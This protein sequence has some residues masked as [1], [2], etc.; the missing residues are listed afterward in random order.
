MPDGLKPFYDSLLGSKK[1][2]EEHLG[3]F[4]HFNTFLADSANA[5]KFYDGVIGDGLL[6]AEDLGTWEHFNRFVQKKIGVS[7][8][9]IPGNGKPGTGYQTEQMLA[10]L[11]EQERGMRSEIEDVSKFMGRGD[12]VSMKPVAP[13]PVQADFWGRPGQVTEVPETKPYYPGEQYTPEEAAQKGHDLSISLDA[14][15]NAQALVKEIEGVQSAHQL[16]GSNVFKQAWEGFANSGLAK[17]FWT[18]GLSEIDRSFDMLSIANKMRDG[19]EVTEEEEMLIGVYGMYQD[20]LQKNDASTAYMVG[21]GVKEMIPYMVSFAATGGVGTAARGGVQALLKTSSVGLKKMLKKRAYQE[22]TKEVGKRTLAYGVGAAAQTPLMPMGYGEFAKKRIGGFDKETSQWDVE[23]A[24]PTGEAMWN[25]FATTYSEV[26]S[27]RLG[28]AVFKPVRHLVFKGGQKAISPASRNMMQKFTKAAAWDGVVDEYL[29]EV[30]NVYMSNAITTDGKPMS[31]V[32]DAKEQLVTFL[33]V[34]V[35]GGSMYSANTGNRLYDNISLDKHYLSGL[36]KNVKTKLKTILKDTEASPVDMANDITDLIKTADMSLEEGMNV[37]AYS[38]KKLSRTMSDEQTKQVS[39]EILGTNVAQDID[40]RLVQMTHNDG[41]RVIRVIDDKNNVYFL[42]DGEVNQDPETGAITSPSEELVVVDMNNLQKMI[43]P[44]GITAIEVTTPKENYDEMVKRGGEAVEQ[45]IPKPPLTEDDMLIEPGQTFVTPDGQEGVVEELIG[46]GIWGVTIGKNSITL[47]EQTIVELINQGIDAKIQDNNKKLEEQKAVQAN[48]PTTRTLRVTK[49]KQ[50]LEFNATPQEDGSYI[51][52]ETFSSLTEAGSIAKLLND[53][54]INSTFEA[55][56]VTDKKDQFGETQILIIAKPK[57]DEGAKEEVVPGAVDAG[58]EAG[59]VVPETG[60]AEVGE[61]KEKPDVTGPAVSGVSELKAEKPEKPLTEQELTP[62][63]S[64]VIEIKTPIEKAP[65]TGITEREFP[66]KTT[67]TVKGEV[68]EPWQM[69]REEWDAAVPK[70]VELIESSDYWN[71]YGKGMVKAGIVPEQKITPEDILKNHKE[72]VTKALSEGK[73]VPDEVL[74]DYPELLKA[75]VEEKTVNDLKKYIENLFINKYKIPVPKITKV[76]D[77]IYVY[78]AGDGGKMFVSLSDFISESPEDIEAYIENAHDGIIKVLEQTTTPEQIASEESKVETAPSEAQKEAGNYKKGHITVQGMDITIENPK[79]SQRSGKDESGKEWTQT[80][81]NTYGYLK[82]T[83]GKDGDQIDVFLG[84]NLESDKVFIIDQVNQDKEFDEHKVMMGFDTKEQAQAAYLSNYEEGWQGLGTITEATIDEFKAWEDGGTRKG[85]PYSEYVDVKKKTIEDQTKE[86]IGKEIT[87]EKKVSASKAK[88]I[89]EVMGVERFKELGKMEAGILINKFKDVDVVTEALPEET[90]GGKMLMKLEEKGFLEYD[91]IKYEYKLTSEGKEFLDAVEARYQTRRAVK[92]GTDLFPEYSNIPELK[93][94]LKPQ[95]IGEALEE[96]KPEEPTDLKDQ[97]AELEKTI[98]TKEENARYLAGGK[99]GPIWGR[100]TDADIKRSDELY[101]LRIQLEALKA[102]QEPKKGEDVRFSLKERGPKLTPDTESLLSLPTPK[103]RREVADYNA[104][105][106]IMNRLYEQGQLSEDNVG[107]ITEPWVLEKIGEKRYFEEIVE[108]KLKELPSAVEK[109]FQPKF[110]ADVIQVEKL[111][112]FLEPLTIPKTLSLEDLAIQSK[113]LTDDLKEA[114]YVLA[115]GRMLDFSGKRVGGEPGVRYQD[116]RELN[117]PV[118]ED[119]EWTQLMMAFMR[120]T[121]AMRVDAN[122]GMIDLDVLPTVPQQRAILNIIRNNPGGWYIDLQDGDRNLALEGGSASLALENIERFYE[123]ETMGT[124]E[125]EAIRFSL[126]GEKQTESKAFKK[127]FG[128][129]KMVDEDGSPLVFYHGGA[130]GINIFDP[131]LAGSIQTSDWG[132]GIYFT[133]SI[134]GA[135]YYRKESLVENDP[136]GDGLYKEYEEK[137]KS[138]GTRPMYE[139]IDLGFDS[140]EYKELERYFD[141]WKDHRDRLRKGGGGDVYPV[142]LKIDN[143]LIYQYVG[144]TEPYLHETAKHSGHDGIII[145]NEPIPKGE[146]LSKYI[147]E[148]IAFEPDQIKSAAV[149]VGT[150][151]KDTPDIRFSFTSPT[152]DALPHIKQDKAA[153][154][155]WKAMLLNNGARQAE[156][157][158]MEWDEFVSGKKTVTKVE[159]QEWI[160]ENKVEIKEVVKGERY[161]EYYPSIELADEWL[162]DYFE[163]GDSYENGNLGVYKFPEEDGGG[164]QLNGAYYEQEEYEEFVAELVDYFENHTD[165]IP[166]KLYQG[167]LIDDTKHSKYQTPGG[168]NY[169]EWLLTM[170]MGYKGTKSGLP[171]GYYYSTTTNGY[172]II[173]EKTGETVAFSSA[174]QE[175]ALDLLLKDLN[176]PKPFRSSHFDEPNVIVHVRTNERTDADGSRALFIEEVQSDWAQKGREKGFAEPLKKIVTTIPEGTKFEQDKFG[177]WYVKNESGILTVTQG[178]TKNESGQK[179]IA[180]LNKKA[181]GQIGT[182]PD[183]PFKQTPQ[184]TGLAIKRMVQY[185]AENGFDKVAWTTGEMQAERYDLSKQVDEITYSAAIDKPGKYSFEAFKDNEVIAAE[186][187]KTEEEIADYLGKEIAEKIAKQAKEGEEQSLVGLDLKVGGEG[188]AAFYDKILPSTVN[189]MFKRY[190][191][192]VGTTEISMIDTGDWR[193]DFS[194]PEEVNSITLT[195]AL[196]EAAN[197]GFPMFRYAEQPKVPSTM[198]GMFDDPEYTEKYYA[199]EREARTQAEAIAEEIGVKVIVVNTEAGLPRYIKREIKRKNAEGMT[200]GLIDNKTGQIYVILSNNE[201]TDEIRQTILHEAVGHKGMRL[202]FG[203][204]FRGLLQTIYRQMSQDEI[205]VL[206]KK[207]YNENDIYEIA[208]EYLAHKAQQDQRPDFIQK[209]LAQIRQWIRQ[210]FGLKYSNNDL[211]YLFNLSRKELRKETT[212]KP[213]A[214]EPIVKPEFVGEL[215]ED[216]V[217]RLR[218]QEQDK[219]FVGSRFLLAGEKGITDLNQARNLAIAEEMEKAGKDVETIWV[220]TGW[221]KG[222]DDKWRHEL[223][224]LKAKVS[225]IKDGAKLPDILDHPKLFEMYPELNDFTIKIINEDKNKTL[226]SYANTKDR[227]IGLRTTIPQQQRGGKKGADKNINVKTDLLHEIQHIIQRVEGFGTGGNRED[228]WKALIDNKLKEF[229]RRGWYKGLDR[230]RKTQ[231][232][233][234]QLID[235]LGEI[236]TTKAKDEAYKTLAGEVEA[237]NVQKR[238]EFVGEFLTQTPPSKTEDVSRD[239]QIVRFREGIARSEAQTKSP[240][241]RFSRK[242]DAGP[243]DMAEHIE[244]AGKEYQDARKSKRSFKEVKQGVREFFQDRDLPL[245]KFEE[246]LVTIGGRQTNLTKPYR[247]MTLSFGRMETLYREFTGELMTPVIK[248]ISKIIKGGMKAE[249]V[250]PY[251]IAKHGLERNEYMRKQ[252][253]DT[254]LAKNVDATAKQIEKKKDE[255]AGKDYSGVSAFDPKM[256]PDELARIIIDE[257]EQQVNTKLL[258]NL[259]K[260]VNKATSYIVDTWEAGKT[261]TEEQAQELRER[262]KYFVPLRGWRQGAAKDLMYKKGEGFSA[263]YKTAHG[264]KSLADNPLAY[265]SQTAFKAIGEQV[266]NEVK[267]S[268][269][270]LLFLNYNDDTREMYSIKKMYYLKVDL[271]DGTVE[272]EPTMEKP[273]EEEFESGNAKVIISRQHE[274][275]RTPKHAKEH[276]V[277][278][279]ASNGDVVMVFND[280]YLPVAQVMNK[281]NSMY[282]K[283]FGGIGDADFYNK[284]LGNTIGVFNNTLKQM[285]TSLNV[286]FPFSN[287]MRDVPESMITVFLKSDVKQATGVAKNMGKAFKEIISYMNGNKPKQLM[288]FMHVGG[289]T[290]FTHLKTPEQLEKEFNNQLALLTKSGILPGTRK[291]WN[292]VIRSIEAWNKLFE[293]AVRYSVYM[294]SIEAGRTKEDAAYDA[295]E[296]SVNFNRKGKSSKAF[297]SL[298]AFWNVAFQAVQKNFKLAQDHPK[299]FTGV[300][301]TMVMLGFLEALLNDLAPG[302]EDDDYYNINDYVRQNYAVIPNIVNLIQ[303]KAKGNKYIRLP[304]PQFWR[305]FHSAGVILY[306]VMTGKQ[307]VSDAVSEGTTNFIAGLSPIDVAGFWIDGEF[308]FSPLVPTTV[309]PVYE[310]VVT[311]RNFMGARISKEPFTKELEKTLAESGL[312]KKNANVAI[313]FLTDMAYSVAGG[314]P[315]TDKRLK[316]YLDDDGKIRK[317]NSFLDVNPSE[318]EHLITGYTGGTGRFVT[319]LV[320]TAGQLVTDEEVDFKNVPFI[321]SFIKKTPEKKWTILREY[322]D[323]KDEITALAPLKKQELDKGKMVSSY[324]VEYKDILDGSDKTVKS[325]MSEIDLYETSS[326]DLVFQQMQQTI[327]Q[328]KELKEYYNK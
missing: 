157:D 76:K 248:S 256:N 139:G 79:G 183:M 193:Y 178:K 31:E 210:V 78:G 86:V 91:N 311:N 219:E 205:D 57:T 325:L 15:Q 292:K 237:R 273:S 160:A 321:N 155:Q 290:G 181:Q 324:Y 18:L 211:N 2:T 120:E 35:M 266:D 171:D 307:N 33:T 103:T 83:L 263:S 23:S 136:I 313:K 243:L 215:F 295:K 4:R 298:Y 261:I 108:Q 238:A 6:T 143:P 113:G 315:E 9:A 284:P 299:K 204:R 233:E 115:D 197:G 109:I 39:G 201:N 80:M 184:W 276:E 240:D 222:K 289:Q 36:D 247:D 260:N 174:S 56:D 223:S 70:A 48:V 213:V 166:P 262:Y 212:T 128:K 255:F 194:M 88:A 192:R 13:E 22:L 168:E 301:T 162:N 69:T 189:K 63:V 26:F 327:E 45:A 154:N 288:E 55:I 190:G 49:G 246:E 291:A 165:E 310:I 77:G 1:V 316:Y 138:L 170:P 68:R 285:Y 97:I 7:E 176:K 27:E 71:N 156:L 172:G 8:P 186:L 93:E 34:S 47:P 87:P 218:Q 60:G 208:E 51:V 224:D 294:S 207:G 114:G 82:R 235:E 300:A 122:T 17:D 61:G 312:H 175:R 282:Y 41:Q 117:I 133:P 127:W 30:A 203:N 277:I 303:G 158:W 3:S 226:L 46:E 99:K 268:M 28:E 267:L 259:W 124:G 126:T 135:D 107:D 130:K 214:K 198:Q 250:L 59:V 137:A 144:I 16:Q 90:L 29:E 94:I 179:Y 24:Q 95:F 317:V 271:P 200:G 116:H 53:R 187:H 67:Y 314:D 134:S 253:L 52:G 206:V 227:T 302:D 296:A 145:I 305:G 153:P 150:F 92:E 101:R 304:L 37:I 73:S 20:A 241:I 105:V 281:Q 62:G 96:K 89:E 251:V 106:E 50:E 199:W 265:I 149:N 121:G 148:V 209:A 141:K 216:K 85:K 180:F 309:K 320:T 118:K 252:E 19:Q 177:D 123:D 196:I 249:N 142:Y 231:I 65:E 21:Q 161:E 202:V 147:D 66:V 112:D 40:T 229:Q 173:D 125:G 270:R 44:K 10:D 308:S 140:K 258:D 232:A 84:D 322:Y 319:D 269:Y 72:E 318:I 111:E 110:A 278:V 230:V 64:E 185:A 293:D 272:W 264:R 54:Y 244:R 32:W 129:S 75:P 167:E 257:F 25:A 81:Q 221:E 58:G 43:F 275:L 104:R 191:V 152:E 169:K 163:E 280:K 220:A 182:V 236:T 151:R 326:N 146:S 228:I 239:R 297:D 188:M 74:K 286:V 279:R 100:T 328:V 14:I 323:L 283:I 195:P 102:K 217:E 38:G 98:Q 5:H 254:W 225:N 245:R 234:T 42:K 242:A 274:K 119:I 11:T 12:I 131:K 132:K 287:F 164:W 306:D 159:I